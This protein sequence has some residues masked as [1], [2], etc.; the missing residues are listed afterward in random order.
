MCSQ[1][2][3]L[4]RQTG[5]TRTNT[6]SLTPPLLNNASTSC[7]NHEEWSSD[8]CHS[9]GTSMTDAKSGMET[10]STKFEEEA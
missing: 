6:S 2:S 9:D 4:T 7:V 1:N 3:G 10:S 8:G 5:S